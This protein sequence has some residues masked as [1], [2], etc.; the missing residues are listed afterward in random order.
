MYNFFD[1]YTQ[2]PKEYAFRNFGFEHIMSIVIIFSFIYFSLR[3]LKK[4][5]AKT[6]EII[7]KISAILVPIVEISH[8]I[9]LLICADANWTQLLSLHLCGMQMY[10]SPLAVFTKALVFKDFIYASSI[11]G[12]IFAIIFPSGITDTYPLWH[13]QTLQT[14]L[15]HGLL[16]FMPIAILITTDYRPTLKRFHKVFMMFMGIVVLA[17]SVDL[18]FDQNYLFLRTAPDMKLLHNMQIEYGTIPYLIFTFFS[19]LII[20]ISIHLPFDLKKKRKTMEQE[21]K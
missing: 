3:M 17:L 6:Q 13:F 16:I 10:F 15:Y 18:A 11:L 8:N 5:S 7:I 19:M 21:P 2:I 14:F 20:C 1:Y 4:L 12:G 9:W